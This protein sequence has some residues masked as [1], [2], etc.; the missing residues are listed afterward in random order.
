MTLFLPLNQTWNFRQLPADG[1]SG[2]WSVVDLPHSPVVA[3][4][5]GREHWFGECEYQRTIA[6]PAG[7]PSGPCT[8]YIGAAMHT[9]AVFVDGVKRGHHSGGYLPFE[10]DL[11]EFFR[12]G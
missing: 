2:L 12:D 11:T 6:R 1:T 10:V 5:D 7:A 9:A 3:D 8:L 4:L